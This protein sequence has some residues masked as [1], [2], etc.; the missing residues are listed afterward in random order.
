MSG[1]KVNG[2]EDIVDFDV[3][4]VVGNSFWV[5]DYGGY[6]GGFDS[7]GYYCYNIGSR[8]VCDVYK[9]IYIV[10]LFCSLV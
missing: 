6:C 5:W 7:W 4:V 3:V 8:V 2:F 9:F 10:S 1:F